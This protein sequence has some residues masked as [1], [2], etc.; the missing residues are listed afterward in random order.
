MKQHGMS[1]IEMMIVVA[2]IAILAG[3]ALPLYS[4][5]QTR[6]R[7]FEVISVLSTCKLAVI[8]FYLDNAGWNQPDGTNIAALAVCEPGGTAHVQ[9]NSV[10]VDANGLITIGTRD[11]GSSLP[12]G[13]IISMRPVFANRQ[14]TG[15]ICGS[16]DDGTSIAPRYLPGSCQG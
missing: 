11:L 9:P 10:L 13:S 2:I 6:A 12:D 5:F 16:S 3:I 14:I 15:W 8:D 1:F 7:T 4:A